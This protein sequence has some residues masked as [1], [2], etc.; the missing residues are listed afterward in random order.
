MNIAA[1][2]DCILRVTGTVPVRFLLVDTTLQALFMIENGAITR[3]YPVSTSRFGIG[4]RE[5]SLMTPRGVHRIA[6]K[7]GHGA[8]VG[9]IFRDRLDTGE[10]WNIGAPGENLVLT[11]VLRLE[12]LEDGVNRGPGI[13]SYERY[14]Y[15]HGTSNEASIGRPASHGCVC[16]ANDDVVELFDAAMEGTIV[17][18]D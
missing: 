5:N 12:G 4:N 11:R 16:M 1:A 14:I 10:T 17:L 15:I 6:E 9:R 7:F 3:K 13:D 18:I 8:P 2:T